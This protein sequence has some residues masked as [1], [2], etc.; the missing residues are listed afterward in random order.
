[1]SINLIKERLMK[2]S[3]VFL[4]SL[5][6][7][8]CVNFL[9][10]SCEKKEEPVVQKKIIQIGEEEVQPYNE[11]VYKTREQRGEEQKYLSTDFSEIKKP[12]WDEFTLY[13]HHPPVRQHLTGTCWCFS[14]TSFLESE[15]KRLGKGEIKLSEMFTVYWE[16][17]EKTRY[18]IQKK[19][20]MHLGQGSEHNAVTIRMKKYGTIPAESYT[21]LLPG[22]TEYD[23]GKLFR[24]LRNYLMFCKENEY[25]D[26]EK[27]VEYTKSIL[28]KYMGKPPDV[29]Q[30]G[31]R[32]ITPQV[33]LEDVLQLPLDDYVNFMSTKSVPFYTQAEYKV[34]DN[35]WHSDVYYNVP[36]DVFY[37]AILDGLKNGYTVALGGDVSEPG[38]SG[39]D[40]LAIIPSYDIPLELI[41]QD[42]RE[43]R[44]YNRTTFDDHAIHAVGYTE[45]DG[46]EWFLIKDSGRSAHMGEFVGYYLF[47]DDYVRLKMLSFMIHK[48]AVSEILLE[49]EKTE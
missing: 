43:F 24:E 33:Y 18:F 37:E 34:P 4:S 41:N 45:F 36:L 26:E 14:T 42:S 46:R 6:L 19:G 8:V 2:K 9:F 22:E 29:I 5:I 31:D 39:D 27:A 1:L 12:S 40:D 11:A 48:D 7:I 20:D 10:V 49:F 16:Y 44:F 13:F 35:W 38:K 15:L 25:W 3:T 17:V 21:G 23:H 32:S 30:G 28:D 47:R